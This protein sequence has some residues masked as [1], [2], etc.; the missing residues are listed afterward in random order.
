MKKLAYGA[1]IVLTFFLSSP[2][3]ADYVIKLKNGGSV[4]TANYWEEKGEIKFQYQGGIVSIPKRNIVSV[5]KVEEKFS[6]RVY[7]QEEQSPA[8]REAPEKMRKAPAPEVAKLNPVEP[9]EG[10]GIQQKDKKEIEIESYK[11]QKAY[12]TEQLEQAYQRYLDA[13]SRKDEEAKKQAW[14]EFNKLGGKVVS[15][16]DEL[17]EKNKGI[18][19]QWWKESIY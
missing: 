12:Y 17:K 6:E 10:I 15:M 4:G 19:P 11:K 16:E 7:R 3:F 2:A 1:A 8:P 13:T 5:L 14:E 18:V 9:S